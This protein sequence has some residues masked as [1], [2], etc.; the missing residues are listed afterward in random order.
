M[1]PGEHQGWQCGVT[2]LFIKD[3]VRFAM[4]SALNRC[5]TDKATLL[6]S[7]LRRKIGLRIYKERLTAR[8]TIQ[9]MVMNYISRKRWRDS[10]MKYASKFL[11]IVVRIQQRF[12]FKRRRE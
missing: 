6:Q 9:R 2:K 5:R 1:M 4:E 3:E 7:A 10:I 8:T 12:R 11:E